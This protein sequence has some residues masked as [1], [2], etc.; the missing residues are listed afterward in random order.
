[1]TTLSNSA[2]QPASARAVLPADH[3]ESGIAASLRLRDRLRS[4]ALQGALAFLVYL[5]AW[6]TTGFRPVITNVTQMVLRPA[7]PDPNISLWSLRW[8]PYAIAHGLNPLYTHALLAPAGHSLAWVTTVPPLAV[9]AAPLTLTAGAVVS[10]NVLASLALPLS[11]WAAFILCRRLTGKFWAGL[12][13]GAVFGF[14]SYETYHSAFGHL[15]LSYSLLLPILGYLIVVWWHAGISAPRFVVAAAA[16][17]AVQFYLFIETFADLTAVLLISLVVGLA[18]AGRAGRP[19]VAQLAK[20]LGLAWVIA[21]ALALPYL[22][23]ALNTKPPRSFIPAGTDLASLVVP[24]VGRTYGVAW[25]AR[26]AARPVPLSVACYVGIPALVL[27]VLL[28]VTS[29]HSR[30]VRLVCCL[31]PIVIAA[32]LG[33]SLHLDGSAVGRLPWA[34]LYRLSL[35]RSSIPVRLMIFAYLGLAVATA[36][37]LAGPAKR[38]RWARWPLAVLVVAFIALDAFPVTVTVNA[39]PRELPAFISSGQYRHHLRRG[40]IVVVVSTVRDAGLLW[41]AQSDFYL[42]IAGEYINQGYNRGKVKHPMDVPLPVLD[43]QPGTP[44]S[45]RIFDRFVTDHHVGAILVD[46]ANKP[47][48]A[49]VF[50]RLGLPPRAV[51]GVTIYRI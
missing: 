1:M 47:A 49:D 38:V 32:S 27:V 28:G 8:W 16:T 34:G 50:T 7:S 12:A 40:E 14:S 46:T 26:A 17:M 22:V 11:A 43:L 23:T 44:K 33:P 18:V 48:W 20:F 10:F 25:L 41:Q 24:G 5:V 19:A 37:W 35:V 3:R 42:R 21:I 30:L 51:G 15:N 36:L 2:G 45:V 31:V 4:P 6:V 13:G 9:L 29:W 39:H